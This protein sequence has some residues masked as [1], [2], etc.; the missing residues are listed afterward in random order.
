MSSALGGSGR[1]SGGSD[2]LVISY[3]S[4]VELSP[5]LMTTGGGAESQG[6]LPDIPA[7]TNNPK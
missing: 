1:G 3:A 2:R 7:P 5:S 4:L 6:L